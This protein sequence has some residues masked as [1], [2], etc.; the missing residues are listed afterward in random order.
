M[1]STMF[2]EILPEKNAKGILEWQYSRKKSCDK[3]E[4][5]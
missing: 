2:S 5:G 4:I 1:M 3:V